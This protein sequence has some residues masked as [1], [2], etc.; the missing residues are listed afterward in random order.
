M[1]VLTADLHHASLDTENQRASDLGEIT[2]ARRFWER[3]EEAKIP[4]T[5]FVS[6]KSFVEHWDELRP[7]CESERVELGGHTWDCFEQGW[8]HRASKLALGSYPGPRWMEA[9]SIHR[10]RAIARAKSGRDLL[11][12][13]NH[14][15]MGGPS[16]DEVLA[17]AG[18]RVRSDGVQATSRGPSVGAHGVVQMPLNVIPDHEHLLHGERTPEWVARWQRELR[19]SDDFGPG[20]Y[21]IEAYVELLIEQLHVNER[22]GVISTLLLH[23]ITLHLADRMQRLDRILEALSRYETVTMSQ[24]VE[25]ALAP[26]LSRTEEVS[27]PA[28]S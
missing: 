18:I 26:A 12:W 20:S 2:C 21:P 8:V 19:W 15:Y 6:G 16:S 11:V 7:L 24:A 22:A 4:V 28:P 9:R 3:T 17:A 23:P 5:F 14:M 1:I 13:R 10:T 27:C 25:R